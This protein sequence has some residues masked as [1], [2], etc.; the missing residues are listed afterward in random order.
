MARTALGTVAGTG[1]TSTRS[2]HGPPLGRL[3]RAMLM[4]VRCAGGCTPE[5]VLGIYTSPRRRS[6]VGLE[7]EPSR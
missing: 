5:L 1:R 2:L 4:P 7:P 3:Y 6:G